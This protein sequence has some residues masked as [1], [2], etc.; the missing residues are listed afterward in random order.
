MTLDINYL[1]GTMAAVL[2]MLQ[3]ST[4]P[5]NLS[6]H[7]LSAHSE[8]ELS[9]SINQTFP[10][11]TF[12]IYNFNPNWVRG[13]ISRSIRQALDQPLNYA[14]IY[15]ADILPS[16]VGRVIY[17]DSDIIVVDDIDKLW[18]VTWKV[19]SS[20]RPSTATPTSPRTSPTGFGPTGSWLGPSRGGGHV[21]STRV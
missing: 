18:N 3:H 5:E 14:R 7:F 9:A 2:S 13:K 8:P 4:C 19:R 6:F 11:L 20:R 15:L 17:F 16:E 1:R 12:R 10:Y 21:T